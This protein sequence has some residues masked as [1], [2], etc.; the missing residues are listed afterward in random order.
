MTLSFLF[1]DAIARLVLGGIVSSG[2]GW[3]GI[4]WCA[5]GILA[6]A[7]VGSFF[8]FKPSPTLV[9]LP[10]ITTTAEAHRT[11]LVD[12]FGLLPLRLLNP[13]CCRGGNKAAVRWLVR[14]P[15]FYVVCCVNAGINFMRE[16]SVPGS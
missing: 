2:V 1:G 4:F 9:G 12:R 6:A 15:V 3:R 16:V 13:L 11:R 14:Q 8:T 10:A 5:A 7:C